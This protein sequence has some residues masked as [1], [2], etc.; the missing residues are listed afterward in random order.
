MAVWVSLIPWTSVNAQRRI[1]VVPARIDSIVEANRSKEHIPGVS[2]YI[3][4]TDGRR[5]YAKG[6]GNSQLSPTV[7]TSE[8]TSFYLASVS[9]PF[10]SVTIHRLAEQGLVNLGVPIGKYLPELPAWRD[11]ITVRQLLAHSSGIVDYTDVTGWSDSS[12]AAEFVDSALAKPL[13]FVPGTRMLYSNT[14]FAL[15]QRIIERVTRQSYPEV[16]RRT[17]LG[18]LEVT[19]ITFGCATLGPQRLAQ[20]YRLGPLNAPQPASLPAPPHYP[21]AASGLCATASDVARFFSSVLSGKLLSAQSVSDLHLILP[22][23]NGD[24][25]SG[26]GLFVGMETTG[27]VWSHGGATK[28]ANTEVAIWPADSLMVVVLT[29]LGDSEAERLDRA[30]ARAILNV[31]EPQV[32]DLPLTVEALQRYVGK[33]ETYNGQIIVT[34]RGNRLFVLGEACTYQG[35]DD[36][37]CG[38]DGDRILRFTGESHDA[39]EVWVL[40]NGVRV[41][42]F[43]RRAQ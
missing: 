30:V 22:R 28:G 6:Y 38:A 35:N 19:E 24:R 7:A 8:S 37:V 14:N 31:P 16:L 13:L 2:L 21:P 33:Y 11:S 20:G 40:V 3:G 27:E 26:A 1:A 10:A 42:V 23:Y 29:N 32:L 34:S 5:M 18:P 4:S 17:V 41:L 25:S 15:V 12:V 39:R 43:V 36:F 9:K